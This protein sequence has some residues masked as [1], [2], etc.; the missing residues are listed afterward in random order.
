MTISSKFWLIGYIHIGFSYLREKIATSGHL[1]HFY[2]NI[3]T[4]CG[5]GMAKPSYWSYL[6]LSTHFEKFPK[7]SNMKSNILSK[8]FGNLQSGEQ[9]W[10]EG[11]LIKLGDKDVSSTNGVCID[12]VENANIHKHLQS[13][14]VF[15]SFKL[16]WFRQTSGIF[17]HN[18]D[19]V[20]VLGPSQKWNQ[21]LKKI[22]LSFSRPFI[23]LRPWGCSDVN[24]RCNLHLRQSCLSNNFFRGCLTPWI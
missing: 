20:T 14:I 13:L 12:L 16:E 15:A 10:W 1:M 7:R 17:C 6:A 24:S 23:N 4:H 5:Q 9:D 18:R 11:T 3:T 19:L 8:S 2:R 21:Y 22:F